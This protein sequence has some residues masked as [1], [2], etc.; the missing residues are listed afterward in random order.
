MKTQKCLS[1]FIV[2]ALIFFACQNKQYFSDSNTMNTSSITQSDFGNLTDGQKVSLFTLTNQNGMKVSITNYGGII[3][4][5]LVPD[6]NGVLGDVVLGYDSLNHYA[7]TNPYFGA[8]IGRYGNRIAKGKFTIDGKAYTLAT[9]NG[10]NHLH[11][12]IKGFDKVIWNAEVKD[13]LE[14]SLLLTY[15]SKDGEEGYPGNLNCKVTYTLTNDNAIKIDFEATTDAPTIVNM[16]NHSYFNLTGENT[17]ILNHSL[18]IFGKQFCA[19]DDNLIPL[20]GTSEVKGTPFDFTQSKLIGKE[21]NQDNNIQIRNGLGYDHCWVLDKR[22]LDKL[23]VAAIA[24]DSISGRKLT[25]ETTEPGIQFYS[26]NFLN[27]T[28]TGKYGIKYNKRS[29][30]CLETQHFPDSPNRPDYPSTI[31]RPNE[32]YA[33][34]TLYK[35]SVMY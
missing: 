16:C 14:P 11:G 3:V 12:G 30:F 34:T 9:N 32:K 15:L 7:A 6:K 1:I 5:V 23:E 31:L 35:F 20:K 19:V 10:Q 21:I 26:G 17:D 2:V 8:I 4:S 18:Q 29:G 24:I 27:G 22:S 33:S 28:I 25:V 13:G